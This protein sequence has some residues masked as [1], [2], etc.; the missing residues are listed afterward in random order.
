MIVWSGWGILIIVF[1][2]IGVL[3]GQFAVTAISGQGPVG[4]VPEAA[5]TLGLVLTA[6]QTFLFTKWRE[7]GP[8]RT[9]IDEAT[10]QRI[11]V[12]NTAGSL[13]FIP[14][15]YW[16]WIALALAGLTAASSL[17]TRFIPPPA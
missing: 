6:G 4:E 2:I 16:T 12:R 17:W 7:G 1:A 3:V 8:S 10:G 14:M 5:I 9:F 15:R 11:E 13:F